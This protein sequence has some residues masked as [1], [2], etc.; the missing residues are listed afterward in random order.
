V[1][2]VHSCV[3]DRAKVLN[4]NAFQDHVGFAIRGACRHG[5]SQREV[6]N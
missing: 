6:V 2:D 4:A 3:A 5:I 1:A